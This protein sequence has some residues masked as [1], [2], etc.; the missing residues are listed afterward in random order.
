MTLEEAIEKKEP[1][2]EVP[3]SILSSALMEI[4]AK[5]GYVQRMDVSRVTYTLHIHWDM[6]EQGEL[7]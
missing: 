7:L 5:G 4:R 6:K 2:I 3:A 1:T